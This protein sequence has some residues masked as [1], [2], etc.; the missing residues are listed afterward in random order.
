MRFFV[1]LTST[2]AIARLKPLHM[3][4]RGHLG[5]KEDIGQIYIAWNLVGLKAFYYICY[6]H[7]LLVTE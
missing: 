1:K 4:P 6:R 5:F 3:A 2:L 7:R